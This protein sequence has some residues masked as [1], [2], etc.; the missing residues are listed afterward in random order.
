MYQSL[1]AVTVCLLVFANYWAPSL[2]RAHRSVSRLEA[3]CEIVDSDNEAVN[4]FKL[5]TEDTTDLTYQNI[6]FTAEHG[7][8]MVITLKNEY[9]SVRRKMNSYLTLRSEQNG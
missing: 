2:G 6:Q 7:T 1:I 9:V 4:V 3:P 5:F 8:D